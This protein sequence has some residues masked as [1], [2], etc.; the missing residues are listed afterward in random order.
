MLGATAC[1]PCAEGTAEGIAEGGKGGDGRGGARGRKKKTK[2]R[3]AAAGGGGGGGNRSA[4]PRGAG[5]I[6]LVDPRYSLRM[7][8][9]PA[10][11][12]P[13]CADLGGR[14]S[15]LALRGGYLFEY[16]PPLQFAPTPGSFLLF[17]AWLMH[18]VRP[19]ML[20]GTRVSVSFNAWL[21]DEDGG[22]R[23]TRRLFEGA[24]EAARD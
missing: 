5:S 4:V 16:A 7:H 19:H 2:E 1:P 15:S 10:Q 24:F 21:A 3:G 13:P 22:L 8:T 9:P 11:F 18:R 17:P 12:E 23:A 14:E 20:K 6:E